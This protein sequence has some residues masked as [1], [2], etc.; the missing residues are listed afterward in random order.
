MGASPKCYIMVDWSRSPDEGCV[1]R[2]YKFNPSNS[3]Q[4]IDEN[5]NRQNIQIQGEEIVQ[6]LVEMPIDFLRMICY[7]IYRKEMKT[8]LTFFGA[9]GFVALCVCYGIVY[10]I[11]KLFGYKPTPE[12]EDK[13]RQIAIKNNQRDEYEYEYYGDFREDNKK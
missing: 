2:L 9:L 12:Q 8:M 11:A 5:V 6:R 1:E 13:A 10:G 7:N 3:I 4:D